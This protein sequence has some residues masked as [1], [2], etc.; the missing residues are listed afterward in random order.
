MNRVFSIAIVFVFL[1][2]FPGVSNA[3][4]AEERD[5]SKFFRGYRGTF[6][7]LDV[8]RNKYIRYNKEQ[9]EKRLSPCSTFKIPNS[10]IG[11]ETGVIKDENFLIKWDGTKYSF[12]AWNRDH[13]LRSA[14]ANSV[15]WYY[16]ELASRVGEERMRKYIHAIHY[17]NEDISG[18]IKKFWLLN[19]LKISANEQV[20]FLR[21]LYGNDLPF[22]QRSMDITKKIIKLD[23]NDLRVFCG[24]TGSGMETSA[25]GKV[26]GVLGWFVGY[27]VWK[28]QSNACI[29]TT[30]IEGEDGANGKQAR[31]ISEAIL[32]DMG[33]L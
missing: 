11:L 33:L 7:M 23:E 29:F 20:D 13:T 10:L 30:N 1:A 9:S 17:G 14:I 27:V 3:Q 19:S 25:D 32:K 6:V 18:G 22:S 12:D 2:G 31:E 8:A 24:K 26:K 15:V 4:A 5:L 16:Q 28:D 21:R